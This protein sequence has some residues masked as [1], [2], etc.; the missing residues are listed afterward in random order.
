MNAVGVSLYERRKPSKLNIFI[1]LVLIILALILIVEISFNAQYTSIYVDGRSMLP[2]LTGAENGTG[3]DYIFVDTKIFPTYGDIVVVE[4]EAGHVIIKR[5]V[6]FGGDTVKIDSGVLYI[7]F[8]GSEEFEMIKEDYVSPEFNDPSKLQNTFR[9]HIVC[10]GGMFLLGD[11]RNESADSRI[12]HEPDKNVYY[13]YSVEDLVGVVP[14]WALENKDK[15]TKIF[16]F[17]KFTLPNA[18]GI[19]T[20]TE[21]YSN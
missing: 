6:A 18:F 5:V 14:A 21:Y 3:G 8:S 15:I 11:N 20:K 1:N 9:E 10:E 16:T 13:D 2:T 7:K 4:P 12:Y 19:R 17:L